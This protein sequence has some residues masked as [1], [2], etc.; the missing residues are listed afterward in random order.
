MDFE[1]YICGSD[2]TY[3]PEADL[4]ITEDKFSGGYEDYFNEFDEWDAWDGIVYDGE[5][6][7]IYDDRW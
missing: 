6:V 4:F 5:Y 1:D 3:D 2:S 7:D